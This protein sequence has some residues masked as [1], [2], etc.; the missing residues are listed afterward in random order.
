MSDD[1]GVIDRRVCV[2]HSVDA[3]LERTR[4]YFQPND[5]LMDVATF[6]G[7]VAVVPGA[8]LVVTYA[9]ADAEVQGA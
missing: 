2:V 7:F 4:V 1:A 3:S 5:S 9:Y 8:R 6:K